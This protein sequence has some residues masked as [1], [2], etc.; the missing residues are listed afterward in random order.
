[1]N[2]DIFFD[3][4]TNMVLLMSTSVIYSLF[5]V[6][7][8][9]SPLIRKIIMGICVSLVGILVMYNHV[10]LEEGLVFDGRSIV[11]LLSALYFGAIPTLI[12]AV[13]LSAY[14]Y[15]LTIV[16]NDTSG[17]IPGILWI[18]IP[19]IIGLSWRYFRFRKSDNPTKLPHLE[20]YFMFLFTQITIVSILFLFPN[21]I[22]LSTISKIAPTIVLVYPLSGY[23][24]SIFMLKLRKNYVDK[25]ELIESEQEYL[26]IFNSVSFCTVIIDLE[27][28][29]VVKA[30]DKALSIYGYTLEEISMLK[31]S[32][33]SIYGTLEMK[34]L[35]N[36]NNQSDDHFF[37]SKHRTKSGKIIHVE[38]RRKFHMINGVEYIIAN[39][40]D[41]TKRVQDEQSLQSI[42]E[43]LKVTIK[44]V[45]NAI[46]VLDKFGNVEIINDHGLNYV[47]LTNYIGEHI[48]KILQIESNH[49]LNFNDILFDCINNESPYES[50][51]PFV[52]LDKFSVEHT[53]EFSIAP[54]KHIDNKI[55][56]A[57]LI[58]NDITKR[59]EESN[60][61]MYHS[62]HDHH[63][64]LYNRYFF[65]AE[66]NRLNTERQLPLSII[67]GDINGL[68]IINDTFGHMEGDNYIQVISEILNSAT[69]IEDIVARWG[70]DEFV[71]LLPQTTSQEA[72][73]IVKRIQDLCEKSR[74]EYTTPSIS[75]G[76]STKTNI[77]FDINRLLLLAEEQMYSNKQSDGRLF[78]SQILKR[79]Y[80]EIQNIHP[81]LIMHA[82]N[83][84]ED[85]KAFGEYIKLN[86]EELKTLI[87]LAHRHDI[88][89]ITVRNKT[90]DKTQKLIDQD[91]SFSNTFPEISYR[92]AKAFPE[93]SH[94]A[95]L[96]ECQKEHYDGSGF[97][98]GY[99]EE[100]IPFLTRILQ[101]VDKV[102]VLHTKSY[103]NE[104]VINELN[105]LKGNILDPHLVEKYIE[106]YKNKE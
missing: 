97:P 22:S 56:G 20:Q 44:G 106:Y 89:W 88:A 95:H 90:F 11:I 19:T 24:V 78:R 84:M 41:V 82:K 18:I 32:D 83:L 71:I 3:L 67:M 30:N 62:Q 15:Y 14:R 99:S 104:L 86:K 54:I 39:I 66:L 69:R 7:G 103:T 29:H 98:Y 37:R 85:S 102:D 34:N 93:L 1:M 91:L 23:I 74:Y 27:T 36:T 42:N 96:L 80:T 17:L 45:T 73:M 72:K 4:I 94:I 31:P 70:G 58:I 50:T 53:I 9:L 10:L 28:H 81:D 77:E 100:N 60:Q 76:V 12:T 75:L 63:T 46:F 16:Y 65:D 40:L 33:I 47:S 64:G 68:K 26:Q 48:G 57:I 8:K 51:K 92:I 38:V 35:L 49:Q 21:K 79:I 55:S 5:D 13:S 105:R 6:N 59:Q 25:K 61:I 52:I 43:K 101:I 87:T 2:F